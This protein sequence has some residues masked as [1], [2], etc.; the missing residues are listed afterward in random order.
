MLEILK[1]RHDTFGAITESKVKSDTLSPVE[2]LERFLAQMD[3]T[4][5]SGENP[6]LEF[7]FV[8]DGA[9]FKVINN[10]DEPIEIG[11]TIMNSF[12]PVVEENK[13]IKE[14]RRE[15]GL[16]Q[17]HRI[18]T[19]VINPHSEYSVSFSKWWSFR[20]SDVKMKQV[21]NEKTNEECSCS[22][23]EQLKDKNEYY[24]SI[25]FTF[26]AIIWRKKFLRCQQ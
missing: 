15:L 1:K 9:T 6:N 5:V 23:P 11:I 26:M 4:P 22:S 17:I 3:I 25:L 7:S 13:D 21:S 2:R 24:F 8:D 10:G 18:E 19:Q 20:D 16:P 12:D 14:A